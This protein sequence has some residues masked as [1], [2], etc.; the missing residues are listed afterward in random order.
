M[1]GDGGIGHIG[2]AAQQHS[3]IHWDGMADSK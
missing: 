2:L 3:T 1:I